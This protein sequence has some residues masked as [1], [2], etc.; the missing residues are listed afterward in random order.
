MK[1]VIPHLFLLLIITAFT[2]EAQEAMDLSWEN[3]A[4]RQGLELFHKEKYAA[5]QEQFEIALEQMKGPERGIR[6]NARYYNAICA[7]ELYH[8]DAEYLLDRFISK[9]PENEKVNKA[10][11]QMGRYQYRRE[12][13]EKV[14]KWFEDVKIRKL[15]GEQQAEFYFKKGYSHYHIGELSEA[16]QAFYE[17]KD[18]NETFSGPALYYYSHIAYEQEN[19]QTALDGFR[20][21]TDDRTFAP[22][23]PYYITQIYYLQE[24]YNQ[25]TEYAPQ[26]VRSASTRRMPEI[27]KIIG[28]SYYQLNQ[29]DSSLT[30]L[31]LHR[32]KTEK[33]RRKDHYQL[34]YVAYKLDSLRLAV[35]HLEKVTGKDDDMAQNAYYHLA[36]CY[37]RKGEKNKAKL[38]FEF[39]SK[40][41]F[42]AE[43]QENALFNFAKITFELRNSPFNDAIKAFKNYIDRYPESENTSD[44][45]NYLVKAYLNSNN[46][47]DALQSLEELDELDMPLEKAY[48]KVAYY[49]GLELYNNRHYKEA[50][51]ALNKSLDY[52]DYHADIAAFSKYW[53]GEAYYH[54]EQYDKAAGSFNQFILSP[55]AF[56]SRLYERAHYNLGYTYFKL[57]D[58]SQSIKWFRKYINFEKNR[59]SGYLAD[60]YNRLGDAYFIQRSYWQCIDYYDRALEV[61]VRDQDYSLF[62]RAFALG[63]LGRSQKKISSLERLISQYTESP[64][65]DDAYFEM[66]RSYMSMEQQQEAIQY[67]SRLVEEY[68]S[69]SY[70]KQALVQLGL[71]HYNLN[72]NDKALRFYKRVVDHYPGTEEAKDALTGIK[73]I[74]VDMNRVNDYFNY[75]NGLG[76]FARVSI[77]EQDSLTYIAAEKIYM[78]ENCENAI[79]FFRKYL[80]KFPNGSFNVNAHFYLA[81]C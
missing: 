72:N 37:L 62:Q 75:V 59:Q 26:F 25:V 2:A 23:M 10:Y 48:Q 32:E 36:D 16:S 68:S 46:Y 54:M 76:D 33:M 70:T 56:N 38:A 5:A 20:Q 14:I 35:T 77:S 18:R 43:I 24:K 52:S 7:M 41:D 11:F 4:Y 80:R 21:L 17:I 9:H 66:G 8:P 81:D 39:A 50:I 3:Q 78:E 13:F 12:H 15:S 19:Y 27:A 42:D 67:F 79:E 60:A 31:Q 28:D 30:Y 51:T 73:N 61:D 71:I 47:K 6:A 55:G 69:S 40:L 1:F 44:A 45:Y 64:Y 53:K 65:I 58:F 57:D 22:I 74:Y 63:L 34:G 49:R 29:Y